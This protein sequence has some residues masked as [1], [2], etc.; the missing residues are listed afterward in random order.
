MKL[1]LNLLAA[2]AFFW[3][4]SASAQAPS[5]A[6]ALVNEHSSS[7]VFVSDEGTGGAGSGFVCDFRGK[8]ALFTNIHV[9]AG[10]KAPRFTLLD[11]TI[12]QTVGAPSIAVGHDIVCYPLPPNTALPKLRAAPKVEDVA[13]IGDEVFVLGN[14]EGAR[15]IAPALRKNRRART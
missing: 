5:G 13:A 15:V 1:S 8:P 11:K 6:S 2:T 10:M 7:L 9:V 12:I 14:S 3:H 4:P